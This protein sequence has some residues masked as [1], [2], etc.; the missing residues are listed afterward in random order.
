MV[1]KVSEEE[2]LEY[3]KESCEMQGLPLHIN[4]DATLSAI[5]QILKSG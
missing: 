1:K 3:I 4:D 5:A 2:I